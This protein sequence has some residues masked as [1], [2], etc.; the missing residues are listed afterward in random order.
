[1]RRA[2]L[3]ARGLRGNAPGAFSGASAE[4]EALVELEPD[5]SLLA[6]PDDAPRAVLG[7]RA[8]VPDLL[9]ATDFANAL[10]QVEGLEPT[11]LRLRLPADPAPFLRTLAGVLSVRGA[12]VERS[13][14]P[15][16]DERAL[17]ATVAQ[18][19]REAARREFVYTVALG[20]VAMRRHYRIADGVVAPVSSLYVRGSDPGSI[21]LDDAL[22]VEDREA[23]GDGS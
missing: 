3:R 20:R 9:I 12:T 18:G 17:M 23:G 14:T 7:R 11:R 6:S 5:P 13:A 22:F 2:R 15:G 1:M 4:R 19:P 21:R 16:A 10:A 8:Q